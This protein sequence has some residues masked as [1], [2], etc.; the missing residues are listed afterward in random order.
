MVRATSSSDGRGP[1]LD[2]TIADW[3]AGHPAVLRVWLFARRGEDERAGGPVDLALE[4]QPVGDS[5]ETSATWMANC[6]KWRA[7]LER[8]TGA[9]VELE[10]LDADE[11]T[12]ATQRGEARM[13]LYERA[14]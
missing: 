10:W 3:A 2:A 13:L 4:L 11:G 8:R 7:Q 12:R 1:A 9:G 6:E 5:E 14:G